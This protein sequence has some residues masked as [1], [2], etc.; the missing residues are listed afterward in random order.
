[1]VPSIDS[2]FLSSLLSYTEKLKIITFRFACSYGVCQPKALEQDLEGRMEQ[3]GGGRDLLP[4]KKAT[5][6]DIVLFGIHD[7]GSTH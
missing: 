1:M 2:N 7:P 4:A 3:A 6:I 5:E